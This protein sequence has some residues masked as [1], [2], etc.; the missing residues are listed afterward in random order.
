MKLISTTDQRESAAS[1]HR[2]TTESDDDAATS[3]FPPSNPATALVNSIQLPLRNIGVAD[4]GQCRS[5]DSG[6]PFART[7]CAQTE[8]P[9]SPLEGAG[10]ATESNN[11][12]VLLQDEN[13]LELHSR[14]TVQALFSRSFLLIDQ[15]DRCYRK[16][17]NTKRVWRTP[18]S[19]GKSVLFSSH[20]SQYYRD[21]RNGSIILS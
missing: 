21:R 6:I 15:T 10:F 11:I 17:S 12:H 4:N 2:M 8:N 5:I 14:F 1:A 18:P 16:P 20:R 19:V 3:V 7:G 13:H 9:C